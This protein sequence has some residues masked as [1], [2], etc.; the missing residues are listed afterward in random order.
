MSR[1]IRCNDLNEVLNSIISRKTDMTFSV[2]FVP[3]DKIE[4]TICKIQRNCFWET[5]N[6]EAVVEYKGEDV[7]EHDIYIENSTG[8]ILWIQTFLH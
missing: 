4:D 8:A 2:R 5:P 6:P 7:Q 3:K 1:V